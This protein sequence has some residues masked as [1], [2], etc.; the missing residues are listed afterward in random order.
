MSIRDGGLLSRAQAPPE[1]KRRKKKK[2]KKNKQ[3]QPVKDD[4]AGRTTVQA[5]SA[6]HDSDASGTSAGIDDDGGCIEEDKDNPTEGKQSSTLEGAAVLEENADVD[7]VAEANALA[8]EQVD[9][10]ALEESNEVDLRNG[11]EPKTWLRQALVIADPFI[12]AKVRLTPSTCPSPL[13]CSLTIIFICARTAPEPYFRLSLTDLRQNVNEL[14]GFSNKVVPLTS[15][16][17]MA[18]FLIKV[19]L[20]RRKSPICRLRRRRSPLRNRKR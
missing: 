15:Y 9:E 16:W 11:R 6:D 5:D 8:K 19:L 12:V 2:E 7:K 4:A 14:P 1:T 13:T 18:N 3:S 10:A 17:A 20:L